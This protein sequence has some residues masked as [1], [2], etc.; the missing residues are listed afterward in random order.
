MSRFCSAEDGEEHWT[1][2]PKHQKGSCGICHSGLPA[3]DAPG[4]PGRYKWQ[5]FAFCVSPTSAWQRLCPLKS[6]DADVRST[7]RAGPGESREHAACV[8]TVGSW[9]F[10]PEVAKQ[11]SHSRTHVG[12]PCCVVSSTDGSSSGLFHSVIR[13][14]VPGYMVSKPR[15]FLEIL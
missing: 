9:M 4:H 7:P 14:I 5:V 11:G 10:V 3:S 15:L 8:W 6:Q 13:G 2:K 1:R 12:G